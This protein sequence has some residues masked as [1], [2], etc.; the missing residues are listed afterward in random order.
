MRRFT[1][2]LLVALLLI[3]AGA[4]PALAQGPPDL[5]DPPGSD[6]SS[7]SG[8]DVPDLPETPGTDDPNRPTNTGGADSGG[9]GQVAAP[10]M[11]RGGNTGIV[12]HAATPVQLAPIEG[13]YQVY[14]IGRGGHVKFGPWIEASASHLQ[15]LHPEGAPVE[16]HNFTHSGT[17]KPVSIVYS[18]G[19]KVIRISTFYADVP[20]H[21]FN[22]PY[23][24]TVD[25][26]NNV[27]H[28]QW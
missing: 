7:S 11:A 20:P 15:H 24:F 12:K 22:K 21:D 17:G 13:G 10:R 19:E 2:A 25:G 8:P 28:E 9:E 16:L 14:L 23:V 3:L 18:P 1:A 4:L 6:T 26:E 27:V 5:P